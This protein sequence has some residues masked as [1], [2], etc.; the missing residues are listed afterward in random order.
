MGT[1]FEKRG[2]IACIDR[3]V[4]RIHILSIHPLTKT[5]LTIQ[6]ELAFDPQVSADGDLVQASF[7]F[8]TKVRTTIAVVLNHSDN[9]RRPVYSINVSFLGVLR[10]LARRQTVYRPHSRAAAKTSSSASMI[11]APD[12][13]LDGGDI[14][15]TPTPG[16]VSATSLLPLVFYMTSK[17]CTKGRESWVCMISGSNPGKG[18]W[19][20][21]CLR[22]D[23]RCVHILRFFGRSVC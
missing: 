14:Q 12:S 8:H 6:T 13:I 19:R 16:S 22:L 21:S 18:G 4:G 11:T 17:T 9:V 20:V 15:A 10:S 1:K 7:R 5:M 3:S 23:H 2:C